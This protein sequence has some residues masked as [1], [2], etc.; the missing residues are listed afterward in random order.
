MGELSEAQR[1]VLK[2]IS[3]GTGD[4][5]IDSYNRIITAGEVATPQAGTALRLV[6]KGY[7]EPAGHLRLAITPAG[8]RALEESDA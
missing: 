6:T 8:R 2:M 3:D 1:R 7:L 4:A 5:V